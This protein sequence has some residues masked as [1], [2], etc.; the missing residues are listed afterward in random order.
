MCVCVG[1]WKPRAAD[2]EPLRATG[3]C[4]AEARRGSECALSIWR[5]GAERS[6]QITAN[7]AKARG[8]SGFG[9]KTET[10]RGR[11]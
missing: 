11:E 3:G 8:L 9:I 10:F 1:V 5:R 4:G 2:G 7:P 6:S